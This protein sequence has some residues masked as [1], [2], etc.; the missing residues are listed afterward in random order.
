MASYSS[1]LST[2]L[3]ELLMADLFPPNG[4]NPLIGG[5]ADTF[6]SFLFLGDILKDQMVITKIM[7]I[8]SICKKDLIKED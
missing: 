3:S 7:N 1:K 2:M 5:G 4:L 8:C 6:R